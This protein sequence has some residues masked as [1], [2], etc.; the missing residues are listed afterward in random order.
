MGMFYNDGMIAGANSPG[1]N[2]IIVANS[3]NNGY[4]LQLLTA[5]NQACSLGTMFPQLVPLGPFLWEAWIMPIDNPASPYAGVMFVDGFGGSHSINFEIIQNAVGGKCT[6]EGFLGPPIST[7]VAS[8]DGLWPGEPGHVA[9]LWDGGNPGNLFIYVNGLLSGKATTNGARQ[10]AAA[11]AGGGG[12][13]GIGSMGHSGANFAIQQIRGYDGLA[14]APASLPKLGGNFEVFYGPE[15]I[16]GSSVALP[17]SGGGVTINPGFVMSFR[18]PVSQ[19]RDLSN[20]GLF[21]QFHHGVLGSLGTLQNAV[22]GGVG[23]IYPRPQYIV[24]PGFPSGLV[25]AARTQPIVNPPAAQAVPVG[26]K[27]FDDFHQGW[28][29]NAWDNITPQ[30]PQTKGGSLGALTWTCVGTRGSKA[31]QA[32]GWGSDNSSNAVCLYS[33]NGGADAVAF[34]DVASA[35]QDVRVSR[36]GAATPNGLNGETGL[37][38]R[39]IDF[40]NFMY[41]QAVYDAFLGG[42]M[43]LWVFKVVNGVDVAPSG[44]AIEVATPNDTFTSIRAVVNDVNITTFIDNGIGGWT[45]VATTTENVFTTGTKC[46]LLQ[47]DFG[48]S[49]LNGPTTRRRFTNFTVF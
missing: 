25:T 4:A 9:L 40:Q 26:C 24:D 23:N 42:T 6:F 27:V 5:Q 29:T 34:V 18:E 13:T 31:G 19:P 44:G 37:V 47:Y 38:F 36:V 49:S 30:L 8:F 1:Q 45:Q 39:L 15:S 14:A 43:H 48:G 20:V 10:S 12:F 2:N 46:G 3:L 16:F 17:Q 33:G 35:T 41:L 21:G 11:I 32:V 28:Q 22:G 7:N